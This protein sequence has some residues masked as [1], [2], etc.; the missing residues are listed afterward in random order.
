MK[1]IMSD[2][3]ARGSLNAKKAYEQPR[4]KM[5]PLDEE[6][7]FCEVSTEVPSPEIPGDGNLS[8]DYENG[9]EYHGD[10]VWGD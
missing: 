1:N 6:E 2:F 4:I 7:A 9:Y 10:N 5:M 8:K 3:C